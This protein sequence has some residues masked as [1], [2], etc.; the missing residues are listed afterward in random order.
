MTRR[1]QWAELWRQ[2]RWLVLS[3]RPVAAV[4]WRIQQ[5]QTY[6]AT[7]GASLLWERDYHDFGWS[8]RDGQLVDPAGK[9]WRAVAPLYSRDGR[10]CAAYWVKPC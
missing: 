3:S 10:P 6:R 5:I 4:R 8:V 9:P 7:H 2:F 1:D